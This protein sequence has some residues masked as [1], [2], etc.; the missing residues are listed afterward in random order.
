ME[1][2]VSA[3]VIMLLFL[4]ANILAYQEWKEGEKSEAIALLMFAWGGLGLI[5]TS[6][7]YSLLVL[8]LGPTVRLPE[9]PPALTVGVVLAMGLIGAT[10]ALWLAILRLLI[11]LNGEKEADKWCGD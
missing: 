6:V 10:G 3:F 5:L 8:L 1:N 7:T 2:L 4:V 9:L 11:L